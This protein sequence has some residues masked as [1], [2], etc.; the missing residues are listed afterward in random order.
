MLE[1]HDEM[2]DCSDS[3]ID[4]LWTVMKE[5]GPFHTLGQLDNYL[6]RLRETGRE[7]GASELERRYKK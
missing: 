7:E 2:M 3:V 4:P 5:G 1:W 6:I